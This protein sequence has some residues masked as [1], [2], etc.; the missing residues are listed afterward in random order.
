MS[1][2]CNGMSLAEYRRKKAL[3]TKTAFN[4]RLNG[5]IIDID[6]NG[7]VTSG[8]LVK[9]VTPC[10]CIHVTDGIRIKG[11]VYT[12]VDAMGMI[13][14][15]LDGFFGKN[16]HLSILIDDINKRAFLLNHSTTRLENMVADALTHCY[17]KHDETGEL[18]RVGIDS[19]GLYIVQ[20][21][22]D[23]YEN[24]DGGNGGDVNENE[25]F[26]MM[27]EFTEE[28][29]TIKVGIDNV[30]YNVENATTN[31]AELMDNNYLFTI[32]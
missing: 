13:I 29:T 8:T 17:I 32:K 27:L 5:G 3:E 30:D 10:G 16:A 11:T 4:E 9:F 1:V 24:D 15:N 19:S 26:V 12:L 20:H 22:K 7:E 18:H 21:E 2:K 14:A 25:P 23:D 28:D 6:L 31:E